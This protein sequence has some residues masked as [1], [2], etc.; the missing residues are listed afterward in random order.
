M[1]I[2]NQKTVEMLK[3][4]K[5]IKKEKKSFRVLFDILDFFSLLKHISRNIKLIIYLKNKRCYE[6]FPLLNY[7]EESKSF[8]DRLFDYHNSP[9]FVCGF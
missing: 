5:R 6:A 8:S 3:V 2:L 4:Q 1:R 7:I 9:Q